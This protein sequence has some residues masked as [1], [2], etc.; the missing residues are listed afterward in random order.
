MTWKPRVTVA[1]IIQDPQ[2]RFLLVEEAIQGRMVLNQP[3]GHLEANESLTQAVIR[4]ALEETARTFRPEGLVGVYRWQVPPA[5]DTYLRFV[6]HGAAGEQQPGRDLD[7]DIHRTLWL[8][9]EQLIAEAARLRSPLVLACLNDFR[10]GQR[11]P[12]ELLHEAAP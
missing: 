6:F 12:L 7:P 5:G 11:H 4:E 1:A 3:A 10:S 2:R 9:H 8:S